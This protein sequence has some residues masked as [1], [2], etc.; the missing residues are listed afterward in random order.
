M[1]TQLSAADRGVLELVARY[2]MTAAAI[3]ADAMQI[4]V[5]AATTT[6]RRLATE[7]W[8]TENALTPGDGGE[9]FQLTLMATR[10]LGVDAAL[11]KPLGREA[12]AEWYAM[13]AF[14]AGGGRVR[15]LYTKDE[16]V[17][18][19]GNL[20]YPGQPVRYYLEPSADGRTRLAY[21][22]VDAGGEGRWDRLIDGCARFVRQ[23]TDVDRAPA[24]NRAQVAAF[25]E[26]VRQDRFQI[27]VLTALDDKRRA[28]ERELV[29]RRAAG[30]P[31]PPLVPH[32]V[33]GLFELNFP[34]LDAGQD[35]DGSEQVGHG[36]TVHE[37]EALAAS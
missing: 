2:R 35:T 9:C 15:R 13:A 4:E 14:C 20:W 25:A 12:R 24:R 26:L 37:G 10:K 8:L 31:A 28:I 21:L 16:F 11:A 33:P 30:E 1:V 32:V 5:A 6:L 36:S 3:L 7:N 18:R 22:K 23:R 34:A 17:E 27:T 19:H 29:R